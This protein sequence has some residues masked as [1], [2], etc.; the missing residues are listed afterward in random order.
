MLFSLLVAHRTQE[1]LQ[2][3]RAP[4]MSVSMAPWQLHLCTVAYPGCVCGPG[5]VDFF[6]QNLLLGGPTEAEGKE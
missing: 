3:D 1:E 2:E 4:H 5:Q 6:N